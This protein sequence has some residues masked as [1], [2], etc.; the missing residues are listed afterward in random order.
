MACS[1]CGKAKG[2]RNGCS[3]VDAVPADSLV[4]TRRKRKEKEQAAEDKPEGCPPHDFYKIASGQSFTGK[5][6]RTDKCTRCPA[7]HTYNV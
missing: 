2:H 5:K 1:S 6:W 4:Y 7:T 3:A